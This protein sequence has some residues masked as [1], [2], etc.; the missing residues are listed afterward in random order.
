MAFAAATCL[1]AALPR[2]TVPFFLA[3]AAVA[4]ERVLENAHYL[5][6]VVAGA[7]LGLM[8][9]CVAVRFTQRTFPDPLVSEVD[10]LPRPEA[11]QSA[12]VQ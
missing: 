12:S 10:S 11:E 2:W 8:C 4:A 7:G 9:G 1:A 5:S 6:D 3:A